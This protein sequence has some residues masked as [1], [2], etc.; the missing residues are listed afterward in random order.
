[1]FPEINKC[2]LYSIKSFLYYHYN[3]EDNMNKFIATHIRNRKETF[4]GIFMGM[5]LGCIVYY[6]KCH[7][8]NML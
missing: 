6:S 4:I 2:P 3:C 5:P 7:D 1:M 8:Y